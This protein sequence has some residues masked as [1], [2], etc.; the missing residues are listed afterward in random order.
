M[1]KE[2]RVILENRVKDVLPGL[3]PG[4]IEKLL[5]ILRKAWAMGYFDALGKRDYPKHEGNQG[6]PPFEGID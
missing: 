3:N 5:P 6:L 4:E 1:T 2:Q